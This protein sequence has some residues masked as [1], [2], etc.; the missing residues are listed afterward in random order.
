MAV[1]KNRKKGVLQRIPTPNL[2][3]RTGR[4]S[5]MSMPNV[6]PDQAIKGLSK[7]AE[8]L[9]ERSQRVGEVASR[10]QKASEALNNNEDD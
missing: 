4:F 5:N 2:K 9:A 3:T 7:A 1:A 6:K 10:V 8:T